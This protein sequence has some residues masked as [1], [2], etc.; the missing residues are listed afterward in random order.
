MVKYP[1]LFI[2]V[3]FLATSVDYVSLSQQ[4]V[5]DNSQCRFNYLFFCNVIQIW[6]E[7]SL[8]NDDRLLMFLQMA[9]IL[10]LSTTPVL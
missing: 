6:L 7:N 1:K 3:H 5:L 4:H 8:H 10:T 9:M 2:T